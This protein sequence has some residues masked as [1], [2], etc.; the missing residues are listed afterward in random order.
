MQTKIG[1]NE[2]SFLQQVNNLNKISRNNYYRHL[3]GVRPFLLVTNRFS[4]LK[5]QIPKHVHTEI[6]MFVKIKI[7]I[8]QLNV[9]IF[10]CSMYN[11]WHFI[12]YNLLKHHSPPEFLYCCCSLY[13]SNGPPQSPDLNPIEQPW[14][15]GNCE[16]F[17]HECAGSRLLCSNCV[18]LS[19]HMG[20]TLLNVSIYATKN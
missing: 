5:K 3:Q 16:I 8:Y 6:W 10:F 2:Y 4:Q 11:H 9:M 20:P 12:R 1:S 14:D 19:C 13:Y 7:L 18:M 17:H 15:E